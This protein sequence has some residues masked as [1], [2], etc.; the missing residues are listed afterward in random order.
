MDLLR[1]FLYAAGIGLL[2]ILIIGAFL[3]STGQVRRETVIDAPAATVYALIANLERARQW[4]PW[5]EGAQ[6][7]A[8]QRRGTGAKAVLAGKSISGTA[9]ILE[10]V[11][12]ERVTMEID[13]ADAHDAVSTFDL[14]SEAEATRVLWTF[15]VDY[16]IDIAARYYGGLFLGR[17]SGPDH[18]R[19]LESL[20]QLAESLPRTDFADLDIE[21][22]VVTERSIAWLRTASRPTPA[23]ISAAMGDAYFEILRYMDRAG[24]TEAGPPLAIS[25]SASGSEIIFDAAIPVAGTP[26]DEVEEPGRVHLGHTY[27]GAAVRARHRGSY[28][29]LG[30]THEKIAA[31]LAAHGIGRN[32]DAWESYETDPSRTPEQDLVTYVYYPVEQP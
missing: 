6:I 16:G 15:E 27:A 32:G 14:R 23:A 9:R 26:P 28:A 30:M 1:K 11:P 18:E 3:P 25:R 13:L 2:S 17:V 22:L 19:A 24:L 7:D 29:T 20:K 8:E 4:L 21:H 12:H 10:T 5:L 31:Y